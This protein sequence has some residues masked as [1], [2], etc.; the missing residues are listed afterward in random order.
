MGKAMNKTSTSFSFVNFEPAVT[1]GNKG[2]I[3]FT[4]MTAFMKHQNFVS[5]GFFM[6][7]SI[8]CF[9]HINA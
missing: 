4:L 1:P 6:N 5:F 9:C 7:F 8:H 3:S 2:S